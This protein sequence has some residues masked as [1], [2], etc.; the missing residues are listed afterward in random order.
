METEK[1][2]SRLGIAAVG[3]LMQMAPVAVYA[4]SVFRVSLAM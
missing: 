1:N 3:F 2:T 4:D